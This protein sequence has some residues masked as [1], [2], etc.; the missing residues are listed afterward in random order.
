MGFSDYFK[1]LKSKFSIEYLHSTSALPASIT[2][3]PSTS[4]GRPLQLSSDE[5]FDLKSSFLSGQQSTL[6]PTAP[7]PSVGF[8]TDYL[9]SL[10][11][12]FTKS[13]WTTRP[14]VITDVNL[15]EGGPGII[16]PPGENGNKDDLDFGSGEKPDINPTPTQ[17]SEDSSGSGGVID[18]VVGGIAAGLGGVNLGPVLDAV[19]TLLRG[20][21]RSA[22]ANKRNDATRRIEDLSVAEN[23]YVGMD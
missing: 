10:K 23:R 15:P 2:L 21:I 8:D 13:S 17:T 22:I 18:N 5:L 4:S 16:I 6:R 20:P 11:D 3:D 12:S 1:S 14:T 9:S 7:G 19:A